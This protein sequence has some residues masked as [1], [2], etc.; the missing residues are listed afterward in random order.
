MKQIVVK[1]F[2]IELEKKK[3]KNMYLKVLPPDGRLYITAPLSMNEETIRDFVLMKEDWIRRQLAKYQDRPVVHNLNYSTG[4]TILYWGIDYKL[5][6]RNAKG[7]SR[8]SVQDNYLV[9]E[10]KEGS[11]VEQRARAINR[12]YRE[13]LRKVIPDYVAKWESIIGVACNSFAIRDMKSCWGTCNTRDKRITLNL[14][15]IKRPQHCLEYVIVHELVHLLEK[16]HN[17]IFKNYMDQ[18]IPRWRNIRK[19]LNGMKS[20]V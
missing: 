4:E 2:V 20:T 5:L 15:L 13:E 9:L 12:W 11:T 3:I 7:R 6:V 1:D 19:E 18:F 14:Q 17:K 16:S 10:I 8:V